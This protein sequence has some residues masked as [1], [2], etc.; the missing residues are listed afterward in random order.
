MIRKLFLLSYLLIA[1]VAYS[2]QV[3]SHMQIGDL[4]LRLTDG[5]I[6][7]IQASVDAM[8]RSETYFQKKLQ[9]VDMYMPII[10]RIFA[11]ENLPDDFKYLVIQESALVSDAVSSSNAV[12]FWQ[13][14]EISGLENDL[15]IDRT[16][17]ERMNIV[18]SSRAA[19]KYL[20]SHNSYFDNWAYSLIAYQAGRGGAQS[21]IDEKN[22][23]KKRLTINSDSYWYLKKFLAHKVAFE[24][25]LGTSEVPYFLSEKTDAAGMSLKEVAASQNVPE[26]LVEE[27]NKWLKKGRVPD[28]KIYTVIIPLAPSAKLT[29]AQERQTQKKPYEDLPGEVDLTEQDKFPVLDGEY[30]NGNSKVAHEI[31]INGKKGIVAAQGYDVD[32]LADAGGLSVNKFRKFNDM[33]LNQK[34]ETGKIYYLKRKRNR[35]KFYYH[36][37]K[38]GETM[39]QISQKYGLKLHK[40]YRKNRI[41]EPTQPKPGRVLWLRLNR[42][43]DVP[44]E[45][46]KL[47]ESNKEVEAKKQ[48]QNETKKQ[49]KVPP[50]DSTNGA[51][52]DFSSTQKDSSLNKISSVEVKLNSKEQATLPTKDPIDNTKLSSKNADI[53]ENSDASKLSDSLSESDEE[54]VRTQL[55]LIPYSIKKGDTFFSIAGKFD[56]HITDLLEFNKL[57]IR[58]T[59]FIGQIIQVNKLI[60]KEAEVKTTLNESEERISSKVNVEN[61]IENTEEIKHTIQPGETMYALAKKYEVS[62]KQL[63]EWNQK[64]DYNVS[65]GEII[66]I[67]KK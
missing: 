59:L 34:L 43:A 33:S 12:G 6:R 21:L 49:E 14:K 2:Q 23:G 39:W 44:I 47:P 35:A 4:E 29:N 27:Y 31:K 55:E 65:L 10:E 53:F 24:G 63:L 66:I 9:R 52:T 16:V 67:K 42:P 54:E 48:E 26:A 20:K 13:F 46:Q 45:Y 1:T 40:L 61:T 7:D 62:L 38:E 64:T 56:M 37:V 60:V 30:K 19:A 57:T 22:F 50:I 18:A 25:A 32:Q 36:T 3:P 58:D 15:R 11:E 17:D 8:R 41:S 28:D 5:A 51:N